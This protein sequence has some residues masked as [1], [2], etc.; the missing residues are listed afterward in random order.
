MI[1]ANPDPFDSYGPPK[2]EDE[3]FSI[4][5]PLAILTKGSSASPSTST[6][7]LESETTPIFA[8]GAASWMDGTERYSPSEWVGGTSPR[9][10]SPASSGTAS[11]T[12]R[13]TSQES[14]RR[15]SYP[16]A[17]KGVHA[18]PRKSETKSRKVLSAINESSP[19]LLH[20]QVGSQSTVKI[21]RPAIEENRL[22]IESWG[23]SIT[24]ASEPFWKEDIRGSEDGVPYELL[25]TDTDTGSTF[26]REN[27]GGRNG[28]HS[29]T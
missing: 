12:K 8:M 9:S 7:T 16:T 27:A 6:S 24:S 2:S 28:V 15:H 18:T 4:L 17:T 21:A 22:N 10:A 5:S 29:T 25:A 26:R 20:T 14:G 13:P 19:T 1:T 11:T 23:K 3:I